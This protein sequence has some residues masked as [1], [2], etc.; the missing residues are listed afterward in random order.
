M[1]GVR[2]FFDMIPFAVGLVAAGDLDADSTI[3]A[4]ARRILR[5]REGELALVPATAA[6]LKCAAKFKALEGKCYATPTLAGG[7]IFVR[8][9]AGELIAFDARAK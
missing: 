4:D 6:K 2:N 8:S 3:L 5:T 9:N 7:R 1:E